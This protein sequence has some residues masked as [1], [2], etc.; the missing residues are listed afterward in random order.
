MTIGTL[1]AA[2]Q[3]SSGAQHHRVGAV[4]DVQPGHAAM[5]V[6]MKRV[7]DTKKGRSRASR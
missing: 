4:P 2:D 6:V 7:V 5:A 1:A 3:A